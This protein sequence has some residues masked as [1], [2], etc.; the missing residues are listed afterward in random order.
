MNDS[1]QSAD[2]EKAPLDPVEAR[3]LACL[4]E[5][6]QATPDNYPLTINGL[7]NACNQ[8]SNREPVMKLSPGEVGHVVRILQERKLIVVDYGDRADKV[9]HRMNVAWFLNPKQQA[10]LTVLMLRKPQTL[11]EIRSRT[12]RLVDF[13]GVEEILVMIEEMMERA[14]PFIV[15]IPRG[16][17][18]REDR[19]THILCGPVD[20]ALL[21]RT[22]IRATGASSSSAEQGRIEMLEQRVDALEQQLTRLIELAE[23]DSAN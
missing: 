12:E 22:P 1:P 21:E 17:G 6:E 7:V 18:Q 23:I 16:A 11:N 15:C 19:Y 5:K 2:E 14:K 3:I 10:I 8:K 9:R 13:D 4:M 20:P